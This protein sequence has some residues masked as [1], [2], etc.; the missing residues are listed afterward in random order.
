[1]YSKQKITIFSNYF[2]RK[3]KQ[4]KYFQLQ[5][6]ADKISH[7]NFLFLTQNFPLN[8]KD[9]KFFLDLKDNFEIRLELSILKTE[10]QNRSKVTQ[11]FNNDPTIITLQEI[12]S[13][14][15]PFIIQAKIQSQR[16]KIS[17][18]KKFHTNNDS[19]TNKYKKF[20]RRSLFNL[21]FYEQKLYIN[22]RKIVITFSF[23]PS[24]VFNNYVRKKHRQ[25]QKNQKI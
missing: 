10:I 6:A 20:I 5:S 24:F 1:M 18:N 15:P 16:I 23:L 25:K 13:P 14:R 19:N 8:Q 2:L 11:F 3:T 17:K 9:T 22:C 4:H 21:I 7:A 12:F